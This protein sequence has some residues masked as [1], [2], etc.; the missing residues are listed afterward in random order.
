MRRPFYT[1]KYSL[2]CCLPTIF[3]LKLETIP[4]LYNIWLIM[5]L[6]DDSTRLLFAAGTLSGLS[7]HRGCF[8]HGEWHVQAPNIVRCYGSVL[9]FL[10][11]GKVYYHAL[12]PLVWFDGL[13]L[14]FLAHLVSLLSSIMIYRVFFHRLTREGFPG[15]L[16]ARITKLWH[17]WQARDSRNHLVL[18]RLH[19]KYGDFVRTGP[20]EITVFLPDAF[21]IIDGRNSVCTKAEWYDLLHPQ[22]ALVAARDKTAHHERRKDW[23]HAFTSQ[24]MFQRPKTCFVLVLCC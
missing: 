5:W 24:G 17:V 23:L 16:A 20:S 15:P 7:I 9:L 22:Q 13:L 3:S 18:D 14:G 1:L 11:V 6:N 19:A 2:K 8:I 21:K 4:L 10:V 12:P